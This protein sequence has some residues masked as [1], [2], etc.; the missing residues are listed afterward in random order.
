MEVQNFL[1]EE[2]KEDI[3][4]EAEAAFEAQNDGTYGL[5]KNW[6]VQPPA[7]EKP[8]RKHFNLI[9]SA[10]L[11]KMEIPPTEFIIENILTPGLILLGAP[12]K[13]CKSYMCLQMCLAICQGKDFLGFRTKQH[14]CLYLDLESNLDRPRKRTEQILDSESTIKNL[15]INIESEPMGKGFEEDL[16]KA[17]K[18]H[19][20]IKVVVVD[21]F[22][23][24]RPGARRGV[25][26]YDRD[27]EDYGAIKA[28][29]DE[30]HL[31]IILVTHTTKMKHPDDPF[32]ELI[33]SAGTLGSVDVA[34]VIKKESRDA[35]TAKL[36]VSGKDVE[37]QCYEIRFDGKRHIWE[38]LGTSQ[39]V[40]AQ[41]LREEYEGSNVIR[42]VKKLVEQGNGHWEGSVSDIIEAS[43]YFQGCQ[44]YDNERQAGKE[45][46]RF[47]RQLKDIDA[48][49]YRA[50]PSRKTGKRELTFESENP[51]L[52]SP[53]S[54]LSSTSPLSPMSPRS[55]EDIKDNVGDMKQQ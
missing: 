20:A 9:T 39:E 55:E 24:I 51:F 42:T 19:P 38:K 52:M 23:K 50:N 43:K 5:R 26:P 40:E 41:R 1:S 25:D 18:E 48:I 31:A 53:M 33:G 14:D 6:N 8:R 47:E 44:I 46:R 11:Q 10:E 30:Y 29:A 37:D 4:R 45:I 15:Y 3:R 21:V 36:Y 16:K 27:Y 17:I 2:A 28:L 22:K 34:M 32:N 7:K 35:E 13:T 12:P 49:T 54:P